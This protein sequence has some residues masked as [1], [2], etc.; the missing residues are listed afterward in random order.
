MNEYFTSQPY[1]IIYYL[2]FEPRYI[3]LNFCQ[4]VSQTFLR[5]VL[6]ECLHI[7]Y[8]THATLD[9]HI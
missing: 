1:P 4:Y 2:R 8:I 3:F 6:G 7:Q 5:I 9:H